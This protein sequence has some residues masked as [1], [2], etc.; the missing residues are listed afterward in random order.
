MA[1]LIPRVFHRIWLGRKPMPPEF[2]E[3]GQSWLDHHP[4]W[5]MKL[6]TED[7]LPKS[8]YPDLLARCPHY[9]QQS[10]VFRYELGLREG[11]VYVDTDFECLKNIEPLIEN[12]TCFTAYEMD[13]HTHIHAINTAFFG[14]APRHEFF[15]D[16]VAGLPG[17]AN[18]EETYSLGASYFGTFARKH[19]EIHIFNRP[20]FYP[21]LWD[22]LHRRREVFP[23]A[24]GV[25]HW[26]SKWYPGSLEPLKSPRGGV[27]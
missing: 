13:D 2:V 9:S 20:L 12:L 27:S 22:E 4:G 11:G 24:Y 23:D 25:H 14:T 5:K 26:S 1:L 21:Y 6:W 7:N 19:P 15:R 18:I 16:L 17:I 3:W 8:R 10:N